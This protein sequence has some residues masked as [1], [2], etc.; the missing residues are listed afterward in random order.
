[1]RVFKNPQV[2]FILIEKFIKCRQQVIAKY[3]L[4]IAKVCQKF[5][6]FFNLLQRFCQYFYF[7]TQL[8]SMLNFFKDRTRQSASHSNIHNCIVVTC[9]LKNINVVKIFSMISLESKHLH[10][11]NYDCTVTYYHNI[12]SKESIQKEH[13]KR[14]SSN[15]QQ[16]VALSP[17]DL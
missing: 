9:I 13:Y 1:M 6:S 8:L 11:C 16:E 15:V 12:S 7:S 14:F 10:D 5:Y 3:K 17:E 2:F 4:R